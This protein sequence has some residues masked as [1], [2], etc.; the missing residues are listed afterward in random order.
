MTPDTQKIL[1][2][3]FKASAHAGKALADIRGEA[4]FMRHTALVFSFPTYQAVWDG[5]KENPGLGI[6]APAGVTG[7]ELNTWCEN[8]F[9]RRKAEWLAGEE[10]IILNE[11]AVMRRCAL[12]IEE[13]V[14]EATKS[15]AATPDPNAFRELDDTDHLF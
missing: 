4:T 5:L 3:L 7:A 13:A 2:R 11:L 14:T 12:K 9:Q 15:L 1:A 10:P 8:E 6:S